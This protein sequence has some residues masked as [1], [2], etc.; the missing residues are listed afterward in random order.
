[1]AISSSRVPI[2]P[3]GDV[4]EKVV[5]S[6]MYGRCLNAALELEEEEEE[7]D[8]AAEDEEEEDAKNAVLCNNDW[9]TAG[10]ALL[11]EGLRALVFICLNAAL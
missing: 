6:F 3:A 1:M 7:D 9:E 10:I 11:I 8:D 2:L 4:L 5:G